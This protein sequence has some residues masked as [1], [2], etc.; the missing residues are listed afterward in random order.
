MTGL[1]RRRKSRNM[2]GPQGSAPRDWEPKA[3]PQSALGAGPSCQSG[4]QSEQCCHSTVPATLLAS[5]AS[6]PVS[7]SGPEELSCFE[8]V[9]LHFSRDLDH[10]NKRSPF[11]LPQS[12]P[13][14]QPRL[15][16]AAPRR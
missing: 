5:D 6:P 9:L 10:E 13:Q 12:R 2:M 4:W 14:I 1:L 7:L 8:K 15:F 11:L 16:A 3:A